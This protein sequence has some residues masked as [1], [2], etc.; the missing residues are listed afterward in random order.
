MAYR[1][2]GESPFFANAA[3]AAS[4]VLAA[5]AIKA[6]AAD[7][8]E[9]NLAHSGVGSLRFYRRFFIFLFHFEKSHNL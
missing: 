1:V 6:E 3:A 7:L 2:F 9:I 5:T 4:A 8:T